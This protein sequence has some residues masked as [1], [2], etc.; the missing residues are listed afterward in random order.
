L[1]DAGRVAQVGTPQEL[2]R[3]PRTVAVAKFIGET[4]LL[5]GTVAESVADSVVVT[6]EAGPFRGVR[7][8]GTASPSI[9]GAVSVLVRPEC[10][11]VSDRPAAENCIRG[12]ITGTTYL[13]EVAQ[14]EVRAGVRSVRVLELNP[15]PRPARAA[16][17][18]LVAD[19]ADVVVLP[20]N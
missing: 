2:Y 6:T 20:S 9:G 15:K 18:F 5:P 10:W 16:D 19:A 12:T 1:L 4:D 17:V 13:G 11:T 14:H 3:R 8:N 7:S